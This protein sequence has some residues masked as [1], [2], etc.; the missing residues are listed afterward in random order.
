MPTWC[1]HLRSPRTH[2]SGAHNHAAITGRNTWSYAVL[3]PPATHPIMP[4]GTPKAPATPPTITEQPEPAAAPAAGDPTSWFDSEGKFGMTFK[5]GVPASVSQPP[6][7]W[8]QPVDQWPLDIMP[9]DAPEELLRVAKEA[10][11]AIAMQH[12]D[13]YKFAT[14]EAREATW[15]HCLRYALKLKNVAR[16]APEV[17]FGPVK[18]PRTKEWLETQ[19]K[20]ADKVTFKVLGLEAQ[21]G[22]YPAKGKYKEGINLTV[23]KLVLAPCI[24]R[25][26]KDD[27]GN[28]SVEVDTMSVD[29]DDE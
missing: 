7:H 27:A 17:Q 11:M 10:Y 15:A 18:S 23:K 22:Y 5:N 2:R 9:D 28:K 20:T 1:P 24:G 14:P 12:T 3:H 19:V 13:S 29:G 21:A 16:V 6:R 25:E 26:S 8:N 4:R